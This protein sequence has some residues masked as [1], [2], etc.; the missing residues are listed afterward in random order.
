MNKLNRSFALFL[1][2]VLTIGLLPTA[3]LPATPSPAQGPAWERIAALPLGF[4]PNRGQAQPG[5]EFLATGLSANVSFSRGFATLTIPAPSGHGTAAVTL[6]FVGG[7]PAVRPVAEKLIPGFSQSYFVGN[8]SSKWITKV[9][10]YEQIRYRD[11]WPGIDA[12]FYGNGRQ[13]EYD[14]VVSPGADA[15]RIRLQ[16]PGVASISSDDSGGLTLATGAG[17]IRQKAPVVYQQIA[18]SRRPVRARYQVGRDGVVRF[19]IERYDR[20]SQLIIDP[21]IVFSTPRLL[22][23]PAPMSGF[24]VVVT[25]I[26]QLYVAG[27]TVAAAPSPSCPMA[28]VTP[29][30]SVFIIKL[31]SLGNSGQSLILSGC[32]GDSAAAGLALDGSENV[33]ITGSTK[34]SNFLFTSN[35]FQQTY[36]DTAGS[37]N[38][39]GFLV[40]LAASANANPGLPLYS[41]YIGS[42]GND[43]GNAVAADSSGK[44]YVAGQTCAATFHTTTGPAY[45]GACDGF[46]LKIDP[47]QSN[48]ASLIYS[49][50]LGGTAADSANG[51]AV[52]SGSN[53]YVAG[54]TASGTFNPTT[55]TGFI[56]ATSAGTEG[57]LVK[58]NSAGSAA[59]WLT[60]ISGGPVS[61]LA[62]D[63]SANAYV[64]G[65]TSGSLP[66]SPTNLGFQTTT[67]GGTDAFLE[68]FNTSTTGA[69]S[70]VYST[71]LGGSG[72]DAGYAVTVDNVGNAFVAG[73]TSSANFPS[74]NGAVVP[75]PS[76]APDGFVTEVN[77]NISGDGSRTASLVLGGDGSDIATAVAT[78]FA[79][80][81]FL[82][83]AT[84]STNFGGQTGEAGSG[85]FALKLALPA[86]TRIGIFRSSNNAVVL[87]RNGDVAYQASDPVTLFGAP[88][89]KLIT[90]DWTGDGTT[91]I[92]IYRP[93]NSVFALDMNGNGVFDPG[94]DVTGVYGQAGDV[95][96]VGDWTGDGRT[97]I[98][99]YRPSKQLF[100]LDTNG[101]LAFDGADTSGIFGSPGDTP[102]VGDWTGNGRTKIGIYR[103]S[104][105]LFV[106][107]TNGNLGFDA[108]VD[109]LGFY[110]VGGDVPILGDWTGD[111][112]T[113]I[114][115]YRPSSQIFVLDLNGNLAFDGG[116]DAFGF[117]GLSGDKP[118]VGDWTGDGKAKIGIF[119][120]SNALWVL[121]VDGNISF[122]PIFDRYGIY[123][124]PTDT[125]ILGKWK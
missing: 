59:T 91:K 120:P 53:A 90:G 45:G 26:G 15:S 51:I 94:I 18:G 39:D 93:S 103:S 13:L 73:Q 50:Y 16:F 60:F 77:T 46:A 63:K 95:P 35:G 5:T 84:A 47:S 83:G 29:I 81:T 74:T 114:G 71:Y 64:T 43:T 113:K 96:I 69:A 67:Q 110:G 121:D 97:K 108:G 4:Q 122:S 41:T 14:L 2:G 79:G 7:N 92:G 62:L 100:V 89:D 115:I 105:Q 52:D 104:N 30:T 75:A 72:N 111:G 44:V 6:K 125:T 101:N 27:Q 109:M 9:P 3:A 86:A 11:V 123:G 119:R 37:G 49:T 117:F 22:T 36:G 56:T 24:G 20:H 23:L 28:D 25:S 106:L 107:D 76:N 124:L 112:K 65:T 68:R 88:G 55:A 10:E 40:E 61:A 87:D 48:A 70:F 38:T 58:L 12:V 31:D 98:G 21:V 80:G 66:A 19:E 42:T 33:L 1:K 118:I 116:I 82:T 32:D 85:A 34:A 8:D 54:S 99:I 17:A 102:I 78:N 57:F